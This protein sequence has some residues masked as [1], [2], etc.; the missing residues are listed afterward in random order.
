MLLSRKFVS[1]YIDLDN[2]LTIN[3]IAESMTG[4]GNEYDYAG[5]LINASKLVTGQIVKCTNHPDSDHLHC[6]KV[7]IGSEVLDI[8]CGAPNAREGIKVIV[9]LDGAILPGGEIKKG[10]IRGEVS[11]GMLCSIA[12]PPGERH[13]VPGTGC[14][15]RVHI[16]HVASVT[17][18]RRRQP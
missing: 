9:A 10:T 14:Y 15:R 12:E 13:T 1:D 3:D 18:D 11:N 8:V 16:F 2:N 17:K 6:C 4:V 5:N 7:N